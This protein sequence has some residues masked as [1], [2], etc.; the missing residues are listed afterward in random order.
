[1]AEP[2]SEPSPPRPAA[3][4]SQPALLVKGLVKHFESTRAVDGVDLRVEPG[5]IRGLLGPNGAGKTTLMR[6]LFGLVQPDRGG[7][8]LQGKKWDPT[9]SPM[10]Q[11]VAGFVE[12]P[13]LYPYLSGRRNLE[14]LARLDGGIPEGRVDEVL[15][16]VRLT[17]MAGRR[18][19]QYSSGM[20]QR[21]GLAAV[22]LHVPR[23]LILDEPSVGL[24]PVG[25]RDIRALLTSLA[26]DGTAVLFSSHNVVEVEGLC[27]TV[28]IMSSGKVVWDGTLKRLRAEAPA[29]AHVLWTSDDDRAAALAERGHAISP[30]RGTNG[31][32]TFTAET[33]AL[34]EYVI[35]LGRE[36][37]AVRR[38]ELLMSPLESM[39]FELTGAR[40]SAEPSEDDEGASRDVPDGE[41]L[42]VSP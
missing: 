2:M 11:G 7:V 31:G 20:R 4:R 26:L 42:E 27:H 34:D 21:L 19:G 32:I 13:S 8:A 40:S 1:M 23:L 9:L 18:A 3:A 24:D 28:T 41:S 14:L 10:V 5:E 29:P 17:K 36:G 15:E 6:M 22:L 33:R 37:I 30:L 38:L 39:F 16:L 35:A 12:A 25:A